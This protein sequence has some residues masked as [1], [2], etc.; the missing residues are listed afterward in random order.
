ML[1]VSAQYLNPGSNLKVD[2][3]TKINWERCC[4]VLWLYIPHANASTDYFAILVAPELDSSDK[5]G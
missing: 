2:R 4:I 5:A 1:F 3:D